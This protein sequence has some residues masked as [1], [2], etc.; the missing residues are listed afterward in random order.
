M[1]NGYAYSDFPNGI[2]SMGIPTFGAGGLLPFTG[3]Y[4]WVNQ[5]TGSDGNPG[6]ADSP[7]ATIGQALLAVS[8]SPQATS[9]TN[10]IFFT[11]T[12]N[13]SA[14]LVFNQANTWLVGLGAPAGNTESLI[15]TA[16]SAT[17]FTPLVSVTAANCGFVNFAATHGFANA[18]AQICWADTGGSNFYS[19]VQIVGMNA[20]T[21]VAQTGGRS[22]T[23]ATK[24]NNLFVNC[25][26]GGT[27]VQ[28]SAA[29]ATLEFLT[30]TPNN[31]FRN[32]VFPMS[33]SAAGALHLNVG[34]TSMA[35]YALFDNCNFINEVDVASGIAL[36]A[37]MI[38]SGTAGG[39]VVLN[40]GLSLG[41]TAIA[42]TGN[43]YVNGAVPVATTSSIAIKAT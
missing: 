33:T 18:S 26:I 17:V 2:T 21:A 28:R 8:N 15:T 34:A 39:S 41:A 4:F 24:G 36:T 11:G 13:L 37:A 20:A 42:T 25:T 19:Q 32:C 7:F 1:A 40:G 3:A 9:N 12:V 6:T 23:I 43:V 29:N 5:A 30:G 10:V 14:T 22:L 35:G 16:A 38:V 31:I 27:N